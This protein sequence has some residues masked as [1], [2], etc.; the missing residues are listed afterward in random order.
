MAEPI[1]QCPNCLTA[2]RVTADQLDAADGLVRCGACK[3]VFAATEHWINEQ[4]PSISD[5]PSGSEV[6]EAYIQDL[7]QDAPPDAPPGPEPAEAPPPEDEAGGIT[8]EDHLPEAVPEFRTEFPAADDSP[9]VAD[10]LSEAL[11]DEA[12][13][14]PARAEPPGEPAL[15]DD[16]DA[17]GPSN[18]PDLDAPA[19]NADAESGDGAAGPVR[20]QAA[21]AGTEVTTAAGDAVTDAIDAEPAGARYSEDPSTRRWLPDTEAIAWLGVPEP[22]PA[23]PPPSVL[24]PP[25]PTAAAADAPRMDWAIDE[26]GDEGTAA[27]PGTGD[28]AAVLP[29]RDAPA[30][31]TPAPADWLP[32]TANDT[33]ES[34]WLQLADEEQPG[35]PRPDPELVDPDWLTHIEPPPIEMYQQS[36]RRLTP[37]VAVNLAAVGGLVLLLGLQYLWFERDRLA[38]DPDWRSFYESLCGVAGCEL[39]GYVDMSRLRASALSVDESA[40]ADG[41]LL[42]EAR[43]TNRAAYAQPFPVVELSFSS[44]DGRLLARRGFLPREYL[45]GAWQPGDTLGAG[46]SVRFRVAIEDPG[47]EAVN[48]R[49]RLRASGR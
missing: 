6:N 24:P 22:R 25:D 29:L 34:D 35:Q 23:V 17:V 39:P 32:E 18:A 38:R 16:E 43:I 40:A 33:V 15:Q 4:P 41:V 21:P 31:E 42:A 47:P 28:P 10:Y 8:P 30:A 12:P 48:Y 5:G 20:D 49:L 2:F 7:L 36:S 26:P 1:T 46:D 3:Q 37:R 14:Q 19:E 27:P 11:L 13:L 9:E 45:T 44:I